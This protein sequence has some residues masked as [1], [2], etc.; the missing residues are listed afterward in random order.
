MSGVVDGSDPRLSVRHVF[1]RVAFEGSEEGVGEATAR[2][3]G[4]AV[5]RVF[6]PI[7]RSYRNVFGSETRVG[8]HEQF[9]RGNWYLTLG[10]ELRTGRWRFPGYS[11]EGLAKVDR[12]LGE[13][14]LRSVSAFITDRLVPE[15]PQTSVGVFFGLPSSGSPSEFR[16]FAP[17]DSLDLLPGRE[18]TLTRLFFQAASSVRVVAANVGI[19]PPPEDDVEAVPID[20]GIAG[21]MPMPDRYV[22]GRFW[23]TLL[24]PP[25]I[26][27][28]GG[29]ERIRAV[30]PV[31]RIREVR[32]GSRLALWLEATARLRSFSDEEREALGEYLAPVLPPRIEWDHD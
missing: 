1:A 7:V 3:F 23:G 2:W 15:E 8:P 22:L 21:P 13:G 5:E 28:L 6:E 10:T 32:T 27:R 11:A 31:H 12:S 30:A 29:V 14:Q 19:E 17:L 18:A 4:A 9:D 25:L 24:T 20:A 26:A 16:V